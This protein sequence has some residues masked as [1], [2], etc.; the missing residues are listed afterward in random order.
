MVEMPYLAQKN[1]DGT[2]RVVNTDTGI[3]HSKHTTMDKAKAQI[4]LL[5]GLDN[6]LKLTYERHKK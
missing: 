2:V 4:R 1:N 6:G 5:H 3:V